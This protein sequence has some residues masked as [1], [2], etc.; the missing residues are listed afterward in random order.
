MPS[1][2]A[3]TSALARSAAHAL[4]SHQN[5]R[6]SYIP[7]FEKWHL[8]EGGLNEAYMSNVLDYN[9]KKFS[10]LVFVKNLKFWI[11]V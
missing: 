3:T 6:L 8:Y 7:D 11:S 1:L 2:V 9:F 10:F 5:L 4:R